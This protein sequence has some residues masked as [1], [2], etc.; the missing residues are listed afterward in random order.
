MGIVKL[1]RKNKDIII[2]PIKFEKKENRVVIQPELNNVNEKIE[3][4]TQEI[5]QIELLTMDKHSTI[6]CEEE[7]IDERPKQTSEVKRGEQTW[8]HRS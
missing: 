2:P 7:N 5:E 3:K 1:F 4:E 6:M 8:L